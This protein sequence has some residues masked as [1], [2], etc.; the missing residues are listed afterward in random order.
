MELMMNQSGVNSHVQNEKL[1]EKEDANLQYLTENVEKLKVAGY[2]ECGKSL[3]SLEYL[4]TRLSNIRDK[5]YAWCE[6]QDMRFK[7]DIENRVIIYR[8]LIEKLNG[9]E[10]VLI[11]KIAETEKQ[12]AT[13]K[14]LLTINHNRSFFIQDLWVLLLNF[15][16]V[17]CLAIWL[18]FFYSNCFAIWCCANPDTLLDE[19]GNLALFTMAHMQ[20]GILFF[21][22]PLAVAVVVGIIDN[23]KTRWIR[24][25]I[26]A[27]YAVCDF[28]FSLA[29]EGALVEA[30]TNLGED[31]AFSWLNVGLITFMGLIPSLILGILLLN[32]K[33][34]LV[35][36]IT[37]HK[38]AECLTLEDQCTRLMEKLSDLNE[39][40]EQIKA[41]RKSLEEQTN[42][43]E[44]RNVGTLWYSGS[45]LT[46]LYNSFYSGWITY[47][48][49]RPNSEATDVNSMDLAHQSRVILDEF[50]D[51]LKKAA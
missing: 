28:L 7:T 18:A 49:G 38:R 45:C 46:A 10:K 22:V 35:F 9:Q 25:G 16:A 17:A 23:S 36:D 12:L 21:A 50:L 8:S 48:S 30:Y 15:A 13:Q 26:P 19:E 44:K 39:E 43:L 14:E 37:N 34:S 20:D 31:Y 33:K 42:S 41:E 32:L 5:Y 29:I 3:G 1:N 6:D 47:L 24:F 4:R 27:A 2:E 11:E 51:N 40:L